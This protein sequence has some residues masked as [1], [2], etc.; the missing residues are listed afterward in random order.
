MAP[1]VPE[2]RYINTDLD[3]TSS[4]DLSELAATLDAHGVSPLHV[5][6]GEDGLWYATFETD[7]QFDEPE[8]NIAALLAAIDSLEASESQTWRSC[9]R[10]EFNIGYDCGDE[11]WSFNQSLSSA[12]L[13]R[14][15]ETGAALR[16][17]LYP[18]REPRVVE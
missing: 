15:G 3:L 2:I 6:R 16:L 7:E 18:P 4:E 14:I 11:P 8:P 13:S 5:T 17:T 10:R 12:I 9:Q 1:I